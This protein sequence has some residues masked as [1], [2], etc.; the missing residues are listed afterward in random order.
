MIKY[1]PWRRPCHYYSNDEVGVN[2]KENDM[3]ITKF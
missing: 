3:S 1:R 2:R